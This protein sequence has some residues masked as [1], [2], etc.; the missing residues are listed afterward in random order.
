MSEGQK[1]WR[2]AEELGF[3]AADTYDPLSWRSF[4]DEPWFG[5]VP[6]LTA[7]ACATDRI[8]LG[9]LAPSVKPRSPVPLGGRASS[10]SGAGSARRRGRSGAAVQE[11]RR[12]SAAVATP[13]TEA[14]SPGTSTM[15][16]LVP[17]RRTATPPAAPPSPL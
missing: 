4:R 9:T 2:R 8:R 17:L 6:T 5:A 13:S 11:E 10:T 1:T 16:T 15:A 7:A 3:H 14:G 12:F